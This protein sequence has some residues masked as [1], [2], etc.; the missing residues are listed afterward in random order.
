MKISYCYG[1]TYVLY[2]PGVLIRYCE[3]FPNPTIIYIN[4]IYRLMPCN[5][6]LIKKYV[7]C[8]T[9]VPHH[10]IQTA[11]G[12]LAGCTEISILYRIPNVNVCISRLVIFAVSRLL[13]IQRVRSRGRLSSYLFRS[14]PQCEEIFA[15]MMN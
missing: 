3:E 7:S 8:T 4:Y 5:C 12:C 6:L 1:K 14:T 2:Q 15:C 11:G 9:S 10:P 13:L